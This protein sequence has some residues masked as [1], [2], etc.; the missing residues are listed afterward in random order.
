MTHHPITLALCGAL[1][2]GGCV[3]HG[4]V[5]ERTTVAAVTNKEVT[6]KREDS[7]KT[8][9]SYSRVND[10]TALNRDGSARQ[11][12]KTAEVC[13]QKV[14]FD[15]NSTTLDL[16]AERNLTFMAECMKRNELDRALVVGR[17]DTPGTNEDNAALQS[18]RVRVASEYLRGFGV[19]QKDIRLYS[20][21]E[22]ASARAPTELPGDR[23]AIVIDEEGPTVIEEEV[24]ID[25]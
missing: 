24:I 23:G 18:E 21:D 16:E 15:A 3:R 20:K 22:L 6:G 11:A 13:P 12:P 5:R 4:K 25:K 9:M 2:L 10:Q 7:G 8:R 14:F 1:A 19:P 17:G